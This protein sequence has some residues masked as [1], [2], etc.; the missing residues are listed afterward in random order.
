MP[1]RGHAKG[2]G[3]EFDLGDGSPGH[4]KMRQNLKASGTAESK[5]R[6]GEF[7]KIV[8]GDGEEDL[9]AESFVGILIG[10]EGDLVFIKKR[11]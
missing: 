2:V 7:A 8:G 1:W 6:I 11:D 4:P 10:A 3:I 9:V 5:F